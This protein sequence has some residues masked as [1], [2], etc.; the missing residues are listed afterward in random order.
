MSSEHQ[1]K[2]WHVLP[3]A[4]AME[5]L[6]GGLGLSEH[7]ARARLARHGEN[8]IPEVRPTPLAERVTGQ[9]KSVPVALLLGSAG[10]S[11]ATGGA[12]DAV[13]TLAVVAL[14]AGI[15]VSTEVLTDRLVRRLG[16]AREHDDVVVWRDG[17]ERRVPASRVAPGD[18]LVL[19]AGAPVAADARLLWCDGLGVD[20]SNLT[21]ESARAE[22]DAAA[23]VNANAPLGARKTMV[24]RG[25]I[26]ASGAGV[27]V[28]TATGQAT[29]IGRIRALLSHS[30]PPPPPVERE[31]SRLG[32]RLT[33]LCLGASSVLTLLLRIRGA[34][35]L[36]VTKSAIALAVSAIP[37][38]LPAMAAST[39]ALA[40][41]QMARSGVFLRNPNVLEA[42]ANI[43]VLCFD[44]TGTLTENRMAASAAATIDGIRSLSGIE[45]PS[46]DIRPIAK[47]ATLCNDAELS[48]MDAEQ[49]SSGSGTELGLLHLARQIGVDVPKLRARFPRQ[50]ALQRSATRLF[51]ATEHVAEGHSFLAVKGAPTDV[52]ALCTM[53]RRRG[54]KCRLD[55][56]MRA[57]IVEQNETLARQGLRVLGFARGAGRLADGAPNHLEWLGLI[58]LHDP[59]RPAA[60]EVVS[61]LQRAGVRTLILTGDQKGTAHKLAADIGLAVDDGLEVVDAQDLRA[62]SSMEMARVA[63]KA[64]VFARVSPSDKLAIIRALQ[65]DGHV[66]AMTGDGVNDGPALRAADVGIAMGKSGS[67]VARDVADLVI[68]DDDL[69]ALIIALSR[70][71]AADD[72]LRR[73][74]HFLLATNASE[75]A[76]LLAE[77][78]QGPE[79]LET[80]AQLFWLNLVTDILPGLGLALAKPAEDVLERPPRSA[81]TELFGAAELAGIGR[82]AL[83]IAAPAAITHLFAQR[84]HG[85]GPRTR[86]LTFLT[87]GARQLIHALRLA[88]KSTGRSALDQSVETGVLGATLLMAAP[89]ALSPLRQLLR[90]EPPR[91]LEA[92]L[93][94]GLS[95]LPLAEKR[96]SLLPP[97]PAPAR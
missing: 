36:A 79:A 49:A 18:W 76:L 7:G 34:P 5:E 80:P 78:L 29:E 56:E 72:N 33:V 77:A 28:V 16:R 31:L 30:R 11:L 58:G 47:I 89:F 43:D 85:S 44:K 42:A 65:A 21:G 94:I 87:L 40:A 63:G 52:L 59:L 3:S 54:R 90:I 9:F 91:V 60:R 84:Q 74:V 46:S 64:E 50:A 6:T 81:S 1:E 71:R 15:G 10:L 83:G 20:E 66:V 92:A 51:M 35:W 38:G 53:V 61:A 14:N 55:D 88:P 67:D 41:R 57:A 23:T 48:T 22:K 2:P 13:M 86:G 96:L 37:E 32:V 8:R 68:E 93:I 27:A 12:L 69:R 70:G 19:K 73:A 75:V 26:V 25:S 97:H 45:K 62:L 17:A 39:K 24:Y 4:A 82:E 95:L